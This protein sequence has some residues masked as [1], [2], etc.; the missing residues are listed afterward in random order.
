[1][2]SKITILTD[3]IP[4]KERFFKEWLY[5]IIRFIRDRIKPPKQNY[6]RSKFRGH[7]AVTRSLV[8]GLE[9]LQYKFNY[10]PRFVKNVSKNVI[11]LSGVETLKQAIEFKKLGIIQKLYAGPNIVV[12]ASDNNS[13]LASPEI[14]IVVTPCKWVID[15]YLEDCPELEKRIISWPAGVNT[16]YWS[17]KTDFNSSKQVLIYEKQNKGNVGPIEPYAEV[18]RDFGLEVKVI[19]YGTF[20]HDE[21]LKSLSESILMVGFV[22]DESQGLAWSEAWSCNIPTFIWENTSNVYKGRRYS[23]STAPYLSDET[24]LFFSNVEEFRH[25]ISNFLDCRY[26]FKPR[27]WVLSNMSDEVCAMQLYNHINRVC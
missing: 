16:K 4:V 19:K 6:N 2:N 7:P 5:I 22:T 12:H 9:K 26:Y 13:I 20:T 21:Y 10:N 18:L 8:E 3:P 23:C 25:Y 11:V 15:V 14:D 1:M 24:G 27:Q 17:S